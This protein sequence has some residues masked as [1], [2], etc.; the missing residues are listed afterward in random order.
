MDE[1]NIIWDL[2]QNNPVGVCIGE[3]TDDTKSPMNS[4]LL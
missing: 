1:K 4:W 2:L 3:S